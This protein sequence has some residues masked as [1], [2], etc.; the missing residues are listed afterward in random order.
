VEIRYRPRES[1]GHIV[2]VGKGITFDTGGLSLTRGT[3]MD[4]MKADMAGA[5][6]IAAACSALRALK[7]PLEVTGLL[8]LAENMPSGQAQRPGDVIRI[9]GGKTVEVRDTDA[10][11]RLILADA[12]AY[13]ARMEPEAIVDLA[14]LTG[15][16]IT[17]LGQYAAGL[18]S[19]DPALADGLQQ[20]G[21]VAG[22]DLWPLP[23]WSRLER[24]LDTPVADVNNTADGPGAGSI[25]AGMFLQ[26][27][28][29]EVP[30]A[31]LDIAGPAFLES[32]HAEGYLG[33]GGTGFG[34][35]TLLSW[36][37]RRAA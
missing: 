37:E 19:N 23:L 20:A 11:G 16:V 9:F 32:R 8:P 25:T 17:A 10:E 15:S 4:G 18:M 12:L 26:R 35:R 31:H 2:L 7:V 5:A 3:S 33:A 36:L 24:F 6:A 30:W 14:T 27:F 1:L 13:A 29:G 21:K 22:E 34:V 28:V